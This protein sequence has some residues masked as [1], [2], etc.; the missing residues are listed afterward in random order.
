M[1]RRV[2]CE[3]GMMS[4]K[5]KAQ[6]R[7]S[8]THHSGAVRDRKVL[9]LLAE[10]KD[11]AGEVLVVN[12]RGL[13]EHPH[14]WNWLSWGDA[15]GSTTP[16]NGPFDTILLRMPR[17][18]A[19][20]LYA[21]HMCAGVLGEHGRLIVCGANDEGAKSAGT[22][23]EQVFERSGTIRTKAHCRIW[24]ATGPK[25][26]LKTRVEEWEES[27]ESP[28]EGRNWYT[29]PGVFA[30]GE[31]DDGT[32]LLLDCLPDLKGKKVLDFASGSGMISAAALDRGAG[33]VT[34]LEVDALAGLASARNVP[35]AQLVLSDGWSRLAPEP[36][37]LIVSNPPIHQGKVEDFS[38]L[39]A[40][41]QRAPEYLFPDGSLI[42]VV[43][44]QV[45]IPRLFGPKTF[46]ILAENPRFW[47]LAA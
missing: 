40:L 9:D 11:S 44:R 36:F 15:A 20:F 12:D 18:K 2:F 14:R 35:E 47:V 33:Q 45:P 3:A 22:L 28:F 34:M 27:I 38:V 26:G 10:F 32:S 43:Q 24:E 46:E 5:S 19:T 17:T 8:S 4:G 31:L 21:L 1:T 16:P 25:E 13:L 7:G 41:V 42:F 23:L 29:Y 39:H 30:R 37:D 6:K